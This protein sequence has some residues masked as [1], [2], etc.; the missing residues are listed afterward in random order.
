MQSINQPGGIQEP[1]KF[2]ELELA[3]MKFTIK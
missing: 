1:N 2:L 3:L